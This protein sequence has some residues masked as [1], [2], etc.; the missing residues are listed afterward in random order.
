MTPDSSTP[1]LPPLPEPT[2]VSYVTDSVM[3]T[4][5][6]RTYC[7]EDMRVYGEACARRAPPAA[8]E[9]LSD[10]VELQRLR[11]LA[12]SEGTR[13]VNYLRRARKAEGALAAIINAYDAYR[14]RGVAPAPT[15][16]A[17]VVHNIEAARAALSTH[18]PARNGGE[19]GE[20]YT[21]TWADA[22]AGLSGEEQAARE[23]SEPLTDDDWQAIADDADCLVFSHL[24]QAVN[25]RLAA[26]ARASAHPAAPQPEPTLPDGWV[27]LPG[28][29]AR[30]LR[31]VVPETSLLE[32]AREVVSGSI[33]PRTCGDDCYHV[34]AHLWLTLQGEV[35]ERLRELARADLIA[36]AQR[37]APGPA[38]QPAS[39]QV[40]EPPYV[41]RVCLRA[42]ETWPV[43]VAADADW[44]TS[45]RG[46]DAKLYAAPADRL[47]TAGVSS[48][49]DSTNTEN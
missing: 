39:A 43:F 34:P 14:R 7:A 20:R 9:P 6:L 19:T 36:V 45:I 4:H 29:Y 10:A 17:D 11:D 49:V 8:A 46:R 44:L 12:D 1:T 40:A 16:Y 32:S 41:A 47:T 28:G 38:P 5:E 30:G 3:R 48:N 26:L 31:P 22:V 2:V 24:K 13:A 21:K 37:P 42:G 33:P 27:P 23:V 15:E 25:R 18:A 35:M